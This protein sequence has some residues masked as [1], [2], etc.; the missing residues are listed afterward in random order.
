MG[1]GEEMVQALLDLFIAL[2]PSAESVLSPRRK[3]AKYL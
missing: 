3:S 1:R 2:I